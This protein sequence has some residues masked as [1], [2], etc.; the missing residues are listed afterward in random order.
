ML[1]GA[2]WQTER[3]VF[4]SVRRLEPRMGLDLLVEAAQI[5]RKRGQEFRI[6]IGGSGSA[7]ESLRGQIASLNL[8]D[9]V[10]LVGRI[11]ED[12]LPLC[13][14]AADCFVLPTRALECFGLIVLES[15]ATGTPVIA[16]PGGAIPELVSQQGDGWLAAE[17]SAAAIADRMTSFLRRESLWKR[18]SLRHVAEDYSVEKGLERMHGLLLPE[19]LGAVCSMPKSQ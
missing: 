1:L 7:E 2:K 10:F 12:Q 14:A 9:S 4:F 3:P 15:F 18:D 13:F 16:T 17:A 8:Q 6:I 5:L 19:H 11:S